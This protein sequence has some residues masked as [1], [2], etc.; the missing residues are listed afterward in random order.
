M[1]LFPVDWTPGVSEGHV[2][3][4]VSEVQLADLAVLF[5]EKPPAARELHTREKSPAYFLLCQRT[6]KGS[7]YKSLSLV[8]IKAAFVLKLCLEPALLGFSAALLGT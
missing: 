2:L 8:F 7:S 4:P 1:F 5:P 6:V 3:K